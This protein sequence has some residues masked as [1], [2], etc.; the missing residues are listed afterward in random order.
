MKQVL[1]IIN[2]CVLILALKFNIIEMEASLKF[3]NFFFHLSQNYALAVLEINFI[4]I[5]FRFMYFCEL[6][7]L[8]LNGCF[9]C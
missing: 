2:L 6:T 7:I 3:I 1:E 8:V 5:F 4:N 9:S